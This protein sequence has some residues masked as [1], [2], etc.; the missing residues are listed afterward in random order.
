MADIAIGKA[1][2]TDLVR[3]IAVH[4]HDQDNAEDSP[5]RVAGA[6]AGHRPHSKAFKSAPIIQQLE[7]FLG[8]KMKVSASVASEAAKRFGKVW[9]LFPR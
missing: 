1:L 8:F 6:D 2:W 5:R 3:Q 4:T 7:A 9:A